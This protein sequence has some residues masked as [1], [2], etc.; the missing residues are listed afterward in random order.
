M[1]FRELAVL[2]Q[3]SHTVPGIAQCLSGL[4][5]FDGQRNLVRQIIQ[6]VGQPAVAV[7]TPEALN[8]RVVITASIKPSANTSLVRMDCRANTS[9]PFEVNM[10][11]LIGLQK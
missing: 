10:G 1:R 3:S 7:Q 2:T 11:L 6:A 9:N 5:E 4:A 8:A